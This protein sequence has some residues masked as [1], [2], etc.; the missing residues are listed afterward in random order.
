[1][2][3]SLLW[4]TMG[5]KLTTLLTE[6]PIEAPKP[7]TLFPTLVVLFLLSYGLLT[8]LV[9]EQ[10]RTIQAQRSLISQMFDDTVQLAHIRRMQKQ[11]PAAQAQAPA[12]PRSQAQTPSA[13]V[14]PRENAKD[15]AKSNKQVPQK[16]PK[17]ADDASDGRRVSVSI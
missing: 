11:Q 15:K 2:R 17:N 1:M 8:L 16:L 10:N 12:S 5:C 13:Q 6:Q 9:V 4:Q 3:T 7:R 14:P